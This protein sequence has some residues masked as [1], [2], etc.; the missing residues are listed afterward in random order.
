MSV[1]LC[2]LSQFHGYCC[3]S[4]QYNFGNEK[5]RLIALR[6][7]RFA[8]RRAIIVIA[9]A[10]RVTAM[11]NV[12]DECDLPEDDRYDLFTRETEVERHRQAQ[13]S[14][15]LSLDVSSSRRKRQSSRGSSG[16]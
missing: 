3:K 12:R 15:S 10:A 11:L 14:P 1:P 6:S 16:T 8:P 9:D 7:L 13:Q 4:Q 5:L 2:S